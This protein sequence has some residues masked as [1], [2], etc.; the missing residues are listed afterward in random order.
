MPCYTVRRD[1]C[2]L[3]VIICPVCGGTDII[4]CDAGIPV[5]ISGW[6]AHLYQCGGCHVYFTFDKEDG[7]SE[8]TTEVTLGALMAKKVDLRPDGKDSHG[9]AFY[10]VFSRKPPT[11]PVNDL[12]WL[13]GFIDDD[14]YD[15]DFNAWKH[16][17]P[18]V[19]SLMRDRE[20][21]KAIP[22][23]DYPVIDVDELL[24]HPVLQDPILADKFTF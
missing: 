20:L 11:I 7:L 18:S 22:S 19:N 4:I 8:I 14:G 17:V 1:D 13:Y 16:K 9:H 21:P 6:L 24:K 12:E 15:H 3:R 10:T 2:R 5:S 23:K